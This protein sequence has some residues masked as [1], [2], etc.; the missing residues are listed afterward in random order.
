MSSGGKYNF[1]LTLFLPADRNLPGRFVEMTEEKK[2]DKGEKKKGKLLVFSA[3]VICTFAASSLIFTFTTDYFTNKT[4]DLFIKNIGGKSGEPNK[5]VMLLLID[6]NTLQYGDRINLG[7]WPWRRNIYPEILGYINSVAPPRVIIFDIFFFESDLGEGNDQY[8]AE[9]IARDGNVIHNMNLFR[10]PERKK[11]LVLPPDVKKNFTLSIRNPENISFKKNNVNEFTLPLP[12]LRSYLR[13]GMYDDEI[14]VK[15]NINAEPIIPGLSVA[16]FAP[17][18]DGVYRRGRILF[19]YGN[20][21]FSSF[22]L[23]AVKS[24]TGENEIEALPGNILK[25]GDYTIPVDDEGNYLVNYYRK[26]VPAYSMSSLMLSAYY[27]QKGEED[28][29]TLKPEEFKDKI[30]II[31]CSAPGCQDL[32]NTPVHKTTPGPEIHAN[33]ISNIL[34][35]NHIVREGKVTTHMI[36][37]AVIILCIASVLILHSNILKIISIISLFVVYGAVNALLFGNFNYLAPGI[38]VVGSGFISTVVSFVYL[39]MTEGAEKRKYSKILGNMIDPTIVSKALEDLEALK[40]GGEKNITAFFSDIAS[41][42]TISEKLTSE[43]LAALLNEYLSAMTIILKK[44]GGTLDK[45]IGDAVVGIFGA[46]MEEPDNAILAARASLEMIHKL[47][48]LRKKWTD[49]GEYCSEARRMRVR[50]GLNTG[51]A[52]VGFM[53]TENLASYTMMGDNVNLAA[54]LEAAGK[55]YGV[56]ILVSEM[57]RDLIKDE[58]FMRK[59]DAVRV[60]GKFEPVLIYELIGLKGGVDE[61]IQKAAETYEEAFE[62]YRK[63]MWSDAISLFEKSVE[64]K[65]RP[66][67]AVD[68]L[69]HRCELYREEPP[70]GDWDGVFT[71]THK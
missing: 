26:R 31:G 50:I 39:S 27:L 17:D 8:F 20:D 29:I 15:K 37:F 60:K 53:G 35:G 54:R 18:S 44:H 68:M 40:R 12:C 55:D 59:L 2:R 69:I 47:S 38:F 63:R 7:R 65:K 21:Y 42:S 14:M 62:L 49:N 23:A 46:P 13:C 45:Y 3:L 6:E 71:R 19:N 33:I 4:Y 16:S 58:M 30:V 52:K 1:L 5:D 64:M 28:K 70:P 43:D 48:D 67:K 11:A 10:N 51:K 9:A 24:Y 56:S 36:L 57:T 66:D 32:K 41:F 25:I 22:S 34:Q 61:N